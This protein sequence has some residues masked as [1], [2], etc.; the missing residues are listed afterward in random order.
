MRSRFPSAALRAHIDV[1]RES[2]ARVVDLAE[3]IQK[4][5]GLAAAERMVIPLLPVA[6]V[7]LMSVQCVWSIVVGIRWA[8]AQDWALRVNI[9]ALIG[10][11]RFVS[12]CI[13]A[14]YS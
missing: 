9:T 5:Q 3:H 14:D 7:L 10:D 11:A 6:V 13:Q 4:Q 2:A 8:L 1:A 12:D